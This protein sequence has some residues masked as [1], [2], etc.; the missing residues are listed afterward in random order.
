MG[1][2]TRICGIMEGMAMGRSP[3]RSFSMVAPF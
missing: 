3:R 2:L 1:S